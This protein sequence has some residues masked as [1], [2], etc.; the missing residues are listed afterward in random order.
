MTDHALAAT[1]ARDA[2]ARPALLA[3]GPARS[4]ALLA[5]GALLGLG[6]A[7][8]GLFTAKGADLRAPPLEDVALVNQRPILASDYNAQIETEFGVPAIQ[9]SREQ[10]RKV[11]EDMIRE[12]LFVQRGLELDMAATD[13]DVRAALVAAVEQQASVDATAQAPTDA[14]L[15]AF[16]D[17]RKDA[18]SSE[19][20]MRAK[21]LVY[22][23]PPS[24][25]P[26][27]VAALREGASPSALPGLR[28][29]GR[30]TGE[31][32]YFAARIHLGAP[33]FARAVALNDGQVSEPM[34]AADGEHLVLMIKNTRPKV[35]AFEAAAPRVA[36]D[37]KKDV[38][39]R[40]QTAEN[41]YLRRKASILIAPGYP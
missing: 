32:F 26:G 5:F 15:R 33:L 17:R 1:G 16:Y 6:V 7:G 41:R 37:Y 9:A 40:L 22:T 13:P 30:L 38:Q 8:W 21:D 10:R 39:A 24:G 36:L 18:Y 25:L 35:Q 23:G 19:G 11:L 3:P 34:Q 2:S 20:L 14:E 27:V 12:E 4:F 28:D 31:E 29:S